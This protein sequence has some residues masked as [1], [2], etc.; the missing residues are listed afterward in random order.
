MFNFSVHSAFTALVQFN[1]ERRL[2]NPILSLSAA[3]RFESTF[4]SIE[5]LAEVWPN[6]MTVISMYKRPAGIDP[7][8]VGVVADRVGLD[9]PRPPSRDPTTGGFREW[10]AP[11]PDTTDDQFN[12][13]NL[14]PEET[15]EAPEDLFSWNTEWR[16][17]YHQEPLGQGW[18]YSTG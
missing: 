1:V 2:P 8:N 12:W 15:V 17:L 14:F 7:E 3:R 4:R 16:E 5:K 9:L 6:V 13:K 11:E 18:T 10:A